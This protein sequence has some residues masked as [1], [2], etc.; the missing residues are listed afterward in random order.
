MAPSF[1]M[2]VFQAHILLVLYLYLFY[3]LRNTLKVIFLDCCPYN[4]SVI[5]KYLAEM[6]RL[7]HDE[8]PFLSIV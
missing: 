7:A 2:K 1:A 8:T 3:L 4:N 6:R 5:P